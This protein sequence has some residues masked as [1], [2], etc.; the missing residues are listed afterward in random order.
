MVRCVFLNKLE[1]ELWLPVLF[2]MLYYNMCAIAPR[3]LTYEDEKKQWLCSVS[4]ALEKAPRQIILCFSGDELVGYIQYYTRGELLMVEEAQ[5][6]KPY[7]K[8]FVFYCMC[9]YLYSNIPENIQYIEAFVDERN[10]YSSKLMNKL[11][12][13]QIEDDSA[14]PFVHLR[15]N[16]DGIKKY[17]R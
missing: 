10:L 16:T 3:G 11:G 2:D 7:Q 13:K 14:V 5:I 9:K 6:R 17:F 4:T 12:M 15:G 1:K 8:T